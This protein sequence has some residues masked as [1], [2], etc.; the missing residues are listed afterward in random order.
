MPSILIWTRSYLIWSLLL[1]QAALTASHVT[2]LGWGAISNGPVAA[3]TML[4]VMAVSGMAGVL[5]E[6]VWRWRM[7]RR[8]ERAAD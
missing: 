4:L 1:G 3:E 5:G 8:I 7:D 6:L 2:G